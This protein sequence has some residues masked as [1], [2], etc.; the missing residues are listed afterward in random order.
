MRASAPAAGL[1]D[2]LVSLAGVSSGFVSEVVLD[3]AGPLVVEAVVVE[4]LGEGKLSASAELRVPDRS[5]L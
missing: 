5:E 1:E 2:V 4:T 3:G